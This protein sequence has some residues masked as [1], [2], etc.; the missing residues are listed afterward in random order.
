MLNQAAYPRP[1]LLP[2]TNVAS[3]HELA[4]KLKKILNR[5]SESAADLFFF[6]SVSKRTQK[7]FDAAERKILHNLCP[8][9]K[10]DL[11]VA[12]DSCSLVFYRVKLVN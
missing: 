1:Q 8:W 4:L 9:K 5:K 2:V 6:R 12:D 10:M 3:L 11:S 7:M